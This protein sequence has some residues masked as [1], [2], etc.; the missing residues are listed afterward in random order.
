MKL[1]LDTLVVESF[2]T[3]AA[4]ELVRELAAP[5]YPSIGVTRD[6]DPCCKP[7]I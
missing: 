7:P 6:P 3:S 2:P 5:F 4:D 1:S